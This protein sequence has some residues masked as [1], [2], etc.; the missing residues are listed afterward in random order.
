MARRR[1]DTGVA[2][3]EVLVWLL[4]VALLVPAGVVGWAIG[5]YTHT[6]KSATKTVTVTTSAS[7][8]T[9][10]AT[11][12]AATSSTGGTTA[13]AGN[14]AAGKAVF[15]ANGCGSCH[16]FKAAG[17]SGAVGPDLDT[18]PAADAKKVNME[19]A[20]FLRESIVNPNAYVASGYPKGVMP[21]AYGT[22]LSKTQLDDL[23]AFLLSGQ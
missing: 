18:T 6:S 17:S 7:T 10:P 19:L 16:A 22:S 1:R 12:S 15:A 5:H 23:V 4:F 2:V 20:A 14:A 9:A 21:Q 8:T 13:A 3:G 11:T